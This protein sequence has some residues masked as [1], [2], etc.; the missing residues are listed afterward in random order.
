MDGALQN[1]ERERESS[2]VSE[3][4]VEGVVTVV[5]VWWRAVTCSEREIERERERE[6]ER[7]SRAY[8]D[9]VWGERETSTSKSACPLDT[10]AC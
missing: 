9:S 3:V 6:R 4:V 8:Q 2:L 5:A 1:A 10:R 7:G